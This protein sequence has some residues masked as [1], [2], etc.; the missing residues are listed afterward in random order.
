MTGFVYVI[1]ARTRRGNRTY[2]GWTLDP[3][4][5]LNPGALGL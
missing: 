4:R 2:V 1:G 5:R 3:E